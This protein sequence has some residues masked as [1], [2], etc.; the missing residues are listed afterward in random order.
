MDPNP[1]SEVLC[2]GWMVRSPR[3]DGYNP[4][5]KAVRKI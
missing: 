5:N 1:E 2:E 4:F 3:Q